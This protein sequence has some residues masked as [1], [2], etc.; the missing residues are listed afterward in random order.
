MPGAWK[1]DAE[2]ARQGSVGLENEAPMRGGNYR[3]GKCVKQ[4]CM[5]NHITYVC[6]ILQSAKYSSHRVPF[7]ATVATLLY[8]C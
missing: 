1:W 2:N 3:T 8:T 6:S 7:V 5:E 4:H